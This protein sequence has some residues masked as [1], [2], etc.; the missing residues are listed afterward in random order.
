MIKMR[1]KFGKLIAQQLTL[2]FYAVWIEDWMEE[3]FPRH[4]S[5]CDEWDWK[6][7][8]T[9]WSN[10]FHF[11]CVLLF[12]AFQRLR[13]KNVDVTCVGGRNRLINF[14]FSFNKKQKNM[15]VWKTI[16]SFKWVISSKYFKF[17][18]KMSRRTM[19]RDIH[20][21]IRQLLGKHVKVRNIR[22][23]SLT[24]IKFLCWHF[25]FLKEF[26]SQRSI[27]VKVNK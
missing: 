9:T 4:L 19:G 14:F 2:R 22:F 12:Y 24:I 11:N 21:S 8:C 10:S 17:G 5:V 18:S 20:E 6:M 25:N 13:F 1:P 15:I 27:D 7:E 23:T 3:S 26:I 16:P